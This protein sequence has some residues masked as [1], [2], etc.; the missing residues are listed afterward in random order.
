MGTSN[1][2]AAVAA[3]FLASCATPGFRH[4][5]PILYKAFGNRWD[6]RITANSIRLRER[7]DRVTSFITD[8]CRLSTRR[9]MDCV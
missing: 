4:A 7:V 8:Q 1:R 6:L 2:L 5:D 3:G 9:Q